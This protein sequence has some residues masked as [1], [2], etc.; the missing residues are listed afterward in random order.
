MEV[1]HLP[2]P[3]SAP[4]TSCCQAH[5]A[6][7]WIA[8]AAALLNE[9]P[10]AALANAHCCRCLLLLLCCS[11]WRSSLLVPLQRLLHCCWLLP[12]RRRCCCLHG[13]CCLHCR[14][15]CCLHCRVCCCCCCGHDVILQQLALAG[16][17]H[18]AAA[19]WRHGLGEGK[20]QGHKTNY[21][22]PGMQG[23]ACSMR[24][25][26]SHLPPTPCMH[27]HL[28]AAAQLATRLPQC[29]QHDT[30]PHSPH[31]S[32]CRWHRVPARWTG[33]PQ[34][35][36]PTAAGLRLATGR[37]AGGERRRLLP[38]APPPRWCGRA[39]AWRLAPPPR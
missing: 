10:P 24:Q 1:T 27:L 39:A 21:E 25:H 32:P 16:A 14:A 33:R 22:Q 23:G 4:P 29:Q 17:Y 9:L 26:Q 5:Q 38:P 30:A 28:H 31:H 18:Q 8:V 19:I 37:P 11:W 7:N 35:A 13:C 20:R 2:A 3:C 12:I 6:V 15:C 34:R 36:H